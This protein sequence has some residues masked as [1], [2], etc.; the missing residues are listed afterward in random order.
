MSSVSRQEV[1]VNGRNLIVRQTMKITINNI[2]FELHEVYH[3]GNDEKYGRFYLI[4]GL[5]E[6]IAYS[7]PFAKKY[8]DVYEEIGASLFY[9]AFN[10]GKYTSKH[11][12]TSEKGIK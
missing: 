4:N 9:N 1:N 6:N 12:D 5:D 7:E 10:G 11:F 3:P 8:P 2:P